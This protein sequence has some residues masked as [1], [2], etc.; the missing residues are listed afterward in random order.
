YTTLFRSIAGNPRIQLGTVDMGAYEADRAGTIWTISN[1]WLNNVEPDEE[2]DVFIEGDLSV[3]TDYGSFSS[4][5]L[6][7]E[8]GGSLTIQEGN[9]ITA[10]GKITNYAGEGNFKIESGGNLIQTSDY[11]TDD[12]EGKITVERDSQPIVRLDYTFWS[13][14][15]KGQQIQSFSPMTLPNRIYTYETNSGNQE[16]NGAYEAVSNVN[17]NFIQGKGYLF[18]APN[19]WIP[20]DSETGEIYT[21]KF[22][23]EPTN[24]NISIPTYANGF[25]SVGN[26]YPSNIDPEKLMAANPNLSNLFFWNNPERVQDEDGN[27]GYAG[28]RY[29]AYSILG[30]NH[31]DYEGKSISS[32][33]GFI[34]YTTN[35]EVNFDNSMRVS[36][37]ESFFKTDQTE[38][39]RFWLRLSNDQGHTLNQ[40]LIGYMTGAT[41]GIDQK[42]EGEQF[43]YAGSAIYN[44]INE[45]KY[46][47]QGRALPFEITDVVPLGF[48]AEKMGK[49]KIS[50]ADFDGLFAGGN[51]KIYL[52]DKA[53]DITQNLLASDYEFESEQGEFHDRFEI[54][55]EKE[56]TMGT[57]SF[58]ANSIQ[59]Y[60]HEQNIIIESKAGKILSVEL[61]DLQGR[62]LYANEK[63]NAAYYQ[64]PSERFGSA[65]LL[66]RV[67]TENG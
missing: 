16:T 14:P 59:I 34:V 58:A 23:G 43:G 32:G 47:I 51:T 41:N 66:I 55:Y 2:K 39:H 65:V 25:T 6:T 64:I 37:E 12:N 10:R 1:N 15:V 7:V 24:G 9:W 45:Q 35:N 40:I 50:L 46:A 31:S 49:Y 22:I 62:K 33:Q 67:L 30:F 29:I 26:P 5:S 19:D 38:R 4:N 36:S 18:R 28:N 53:M 48:N 57:D 11:E 44:L 60:Q 56:E 21:G 27:W 52:R 42:I 61:F 13:S 3:G 20:E 8:D 54:V 63:V 17:S